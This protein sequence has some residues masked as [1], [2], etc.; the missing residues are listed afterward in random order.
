MRQ[1][2]VVVAVGTHARTVHPAIAR[3]AVL[4]VQRIDRRNE[5]AAVAVGLLGRGEQVP[6]DLHHRLL[7]TLAAGGWTAISD[8]ATHVLDRPRDRRLDQLVRYSSLQELFNA[9]A[10]LQRSFHVGHATTFEIC[11]ASVRVRHDASLGQPPMPAESLFLAAVQRHVIGVCAGA[12]PAITVTLADGC[13]VDPDVEFAGAVSGRRISHWEFGPLDISPPGRPSVT[14]Q[15]ENVVGRDP[16]RSWRLDDIS[17]RLAMSTRALQRSL[18]TEGT[19]FRAC[20]RS[21]RLVL[22]RSLVERTDLSIGSIAAATGFADHAHLTRCYRAT[23][24]TNPIRA[25]STPTPS[26]P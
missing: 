9:G 22:A 26:T 23:F 8:A 15:V 20:V 16:T 2:A 17:G 1:N 11:H 4:G 19:T 10:E 12:T 7:A 18:Q 25:R 5:A 24:G 3:A 21:T 14:T 13:G 6:E